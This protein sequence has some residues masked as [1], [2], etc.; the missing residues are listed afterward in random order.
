[1]VAST[2]SDESIAFRLANVAD[3]EAESAFV[4]ASAQILKYIVDFVALSLLIEESAAA[5]TA[6]VDLVA[7][8]E[9]SEVSE[10]ERTNAAERVV[11][12]A[13]LLLSI[14]FRFS[15]STRVTASTFVEE[16][17]VERI[18]TACVLATASVSI[19]V[20]EAKRR[21]ALEMPALSVLRL[22]SVMPRINDWVARTVTSVLSDESVAILGR[23][24]D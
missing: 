23:D 5:R 10:T 21:I 15:V 13:L 22:E 6:V 11:V 9:L 14:A 3:R 7:M 16:S 18:N 12:S 24:S 2:L 1:M 19:E 20:S 4:L 8:S 17:V